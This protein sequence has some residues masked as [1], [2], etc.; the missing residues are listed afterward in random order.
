MMLMGLLY[1]TNSVHAERGAG[2]WVVI[3]TIYIFAI[4][5]STTWAIGV[6]LFASEIQPAATRATA[7]SLAQAANCIT[8]F[9]VAFVTPVVLSHSSSAVYFFFGGATIL[10]VGVCAVYMPE[11]RGRDLESIVQAFGLPGETA[12]MPLA[13]ALRSLKSA[14][15]YA[16]G[17]QWAQWR[18]ASQTEAGGT[19]LATR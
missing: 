18:H 11:T 16:V 12:S 5:Y 4:A 3:V 17:A 10:T 2:R 1:A 9:V 15:R 14:A 8:N 13:K 7:V 19:E 6:K